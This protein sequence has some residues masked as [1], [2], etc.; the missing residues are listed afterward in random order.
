MADRNWLGE[1][2]GAIEQ[3][4]ESM[5]GTA[6]PISDE[7]NLARTQHLAAIA[8]AK[9]TVANAEAVLSLR[10]QLEELP[11]QIERRLRER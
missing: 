9:A 11:A 3:A 6:L 8:I 10:D 7:G 4:E 5:K 2:Y 1:S